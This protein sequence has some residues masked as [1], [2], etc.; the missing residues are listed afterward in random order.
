MGCWIGS[1][2]LTDSRPR[3]RGPDMCQRKKGRRMPAFCSSL[4]ATCGQRTNEEQVCCSRRRRRMDRIVSLWDK[5]RSPIPS[6][7]LS[8][9][10]HKRSSFRTTCFTTWYTLLSLSH[11]TEGFNVNKFTVQRA[12]LRLTE[13]GKQAAKQSPICPYRSFLPSVT[14][15]NKIFFPCT[16]NPNTILTK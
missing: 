12:T 9:K 6:R 15:Q 3:A 1:M 2:A 5:K 11:L 8:F 4:S 13:D 16:I 10:G 14:R 7:G